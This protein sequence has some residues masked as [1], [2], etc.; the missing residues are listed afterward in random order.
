MRRRAFFG[1]VGVAV[2][3]PLA[4]RSQSGQGPALIGSLALRSRDPS[5]DVIARVKEGLTALGW[6]EGAQFVIEERWANGQPDRL[7]PL[8]DELAAMRPAVILAWP[9]IAVVFASKAAPNTPIV[10]A[11][12][13][14]IGSGIVK[15]VAH[16]EGMITGVAN[17]VSDTVGKQAELLISVS[18]QLQHVGVLGDSTTPEVSRAGFKEA[19]YRAA[20][21]HSIE[22]SY[23]EITRPEEIEQAILRLAEAGSQAL[24]ATPSST[25]VAERQRI[26]DLAAVRRWPVAGWS[27][28]WARSGALLSYGANNAESYRR[29]AYFI[30]RI[31]KGAKPGDLPVEQPTK[32]ELVINMK[33]A[34]TLGLSVPISLQ[35]QA[36]EVIE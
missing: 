18:P 31:L 25:F 9:S 20:T 6:K 3:W 5:A 16:P 7:Q 29:A 34:K 11:A 35:A 12:T 4:A 13:D 23:E 24:I 33:S 14:A 36:D 32:I 8:A 21:Q 10:F 28:E 19:A 15:N 1:L 27:I 26:V 2:A 17:I 30:D 22:V